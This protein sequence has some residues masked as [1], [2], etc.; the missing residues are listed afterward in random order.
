MDHTDIAKEI[1]SLQKSDLELRDKLIQ[2][3]ELSDG[4]NNEMEALHNRHAKILNNII[5]K[6]GYPTVDQVGKEANEAA[7]LVVQHSIGQPE[8]MK[9]CAF[10]LEKSVAE[11]QADA[12]QLAYLTDRIAVFEGRPQLYGT[13]FDWD[14]NGEMNPNSFEELEIANQRR[15][16]IGLNSLEEQTTIIRKQVIAENQKPPANIKERAK[17]FDE[18]RKKVG[19]I[20]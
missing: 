19:W 6:I 11:N 7:W 9:K 10:L 3:G 15:K 12:K 13:Q 20:K 18:W 5:D 17:E 8:F 14:E 2:N 16:K 4:Y 1:I